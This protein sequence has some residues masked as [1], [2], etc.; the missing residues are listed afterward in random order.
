MNKNSRLALKNQM[1]K[2]GSI[3]EYKIK[4]DFERKRLHHKLTPWKVN[5]VFQIPY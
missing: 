5:D 3:F 1:N 4:S 2:I